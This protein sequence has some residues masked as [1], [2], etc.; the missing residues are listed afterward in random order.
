MDLFL[1]IS[2]MLPL[3]IGVRWLGALSPLVGYRAWG[4]KVID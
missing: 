3:Y 1:H 4:R 2:C